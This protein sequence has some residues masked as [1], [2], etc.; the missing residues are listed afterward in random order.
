[1]I[2]LRKW[3]LYITKEPIN[4]ASEQSLC[5]HGPYTLGNIAKGGQKASKHINRSISDNK[6]HK[7]SKTR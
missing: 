3:N 6:C 1:M 5:T 4:Q 2:K 7:G